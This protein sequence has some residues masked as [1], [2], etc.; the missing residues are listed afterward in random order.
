MEDGALNGMEEQ[1]MTSCQSKLPEIT[2]KLTTPKAVMVVMDKYLLEY[3]ALNVPIR[4]GEI[5]ITCSHIS[6]DRKH[7]EVVN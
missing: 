4:Y 2:K 6:K 3:Q 1:I 7:S 5:S